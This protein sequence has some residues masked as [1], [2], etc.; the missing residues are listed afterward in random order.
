VGTYASEG[1]ITVSNSLRSAIHIDNLVVKVDFADGS[2]DAIPLADASSVAIGAGGESILHTSLNTRKQPTAAA[3][4]T[5]DYHVAG[6]QP[7]TGRIR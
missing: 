1:T 4:V 2:S 5:L 3:I 6:G 7:C